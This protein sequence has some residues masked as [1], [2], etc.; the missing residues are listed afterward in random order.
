[1]TIEALVSGQP[2]KQ[3]AETA[4][5]HEMK[6]RPVMPKNT[7]REFLVP[8]RITQDGEVIVQAKDADEARSKAENGD[9]QLFIES[10][11][12]D[13]ETRGPAIPNE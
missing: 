12:R 8:M 6:E 4:R 2:L 5:S 1:M 7:E 10:E 11:C 9:W 13:W 3:G